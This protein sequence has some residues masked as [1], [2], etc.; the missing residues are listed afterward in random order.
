MKNWRAENRRFMINLLI[1]WGYK[2][3]C[4]KIDTND[5]RFVLYKFLCVVTKSRTLSALCTFSQKDVEV[6]MG[7]KLIYI[8]KS[9]HAIKALYKNI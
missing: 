5:K 2:A 9:L 3:N 7:Q 8:D 6:D 1:D 4:D